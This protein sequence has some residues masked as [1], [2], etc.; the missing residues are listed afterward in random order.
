MHG[1]TRWGT[2]HGMCKRGRELSVPIGR[3]IAAA[4]DRFGP[5]TVLRKEGKI[6]KK[7]PWSAFAFK[8]SDWERIGECMLILQDA[9][10]IQQL[11]T[12]PKVATMHRVIPA[13]ENLLT[14]W[15]EKRA[16]PKFLVFDSALAKGIKKIEKYYHL[17][18][19]K[20]AYLI[21]LRA[22]F[23]FL[24]ILFIAHN[25]TV[26]HPYFKLDWITDH[27][28]GPEEQA[29]EIAEG[30]KK[31]KNWQA[32]GMKVAETMVRPSSHSHLCTDA[33]S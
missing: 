17:F 9:N 7:I 33:L 31:A 10:A 23:S 13:I 16:D 3:F 21:G 27:W 11:F 18:D 25:S 22:V 32:E 20:P 26:I 2:A 5:I 1:N 15:E 24:G 12:T 29:R 8:D 4:N 6:I 30:N 14:Q 28:G 19:G